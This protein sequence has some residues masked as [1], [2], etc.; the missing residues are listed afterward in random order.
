MYKSCPE[1]R[2][3]LMANANK[4]VKSNIKLYSKLATGADSQPLAG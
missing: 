1:R 2:Q 4:V 3:K